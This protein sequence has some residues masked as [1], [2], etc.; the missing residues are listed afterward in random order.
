MAIGKSMKGRFSHVK[1]IAM[2]EKSGWIFAAHIYYYYKNEV[3]LWDSKTCEMVGQPII[4]SQSSG[5]T[6]APVSSNGKMIVTGSYQGTLHR[7]CATTCDAIGKPMLARV[8][9]WNG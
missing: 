8:I 5:L 4:F 1:S 3:I 7:Y 6:C 9:L 2:N